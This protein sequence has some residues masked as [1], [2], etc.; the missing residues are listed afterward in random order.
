MMILVPYIIGENF[1]NVFPMVYDTK[2]AMILKK[3][4]IS[5]NK[6]ESMIKKRGRKVEVKIKNVQERGPTFLFRPLIFHGVS[7][8]P[9]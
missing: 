5:C 6:L 7:I 4:K 1:K 9:A 8:L 3:M 2:I